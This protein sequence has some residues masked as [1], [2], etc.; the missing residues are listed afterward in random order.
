MCATSCVASSGGPDLAA[1]HGRQGDVRQRERRKLPQRRGRAPLRNRQAENEQRQQPLAKHLGGRPAQK[2]RH[3][4][5]QGRLE[6]H[7]LWRPGD[8]EGPRPN[9]RE[10]DTSRASGR[11]R[12]PGAAHSGAPTRRANPTQR[13]N[14]PG[15][16]RT[17]RSSR[18]N[19][20]VESELLPDDARRLRTSRTNCRQKGRRSTTPAQEQSAFHDP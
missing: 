1:T 11:N 15:S 3:G 18:R 6:N 10:A 8:R 13:R 9:R 20:Q 12:R 7:P 2:C 5:R 14:P 4:V 19:D 16:R 17:P